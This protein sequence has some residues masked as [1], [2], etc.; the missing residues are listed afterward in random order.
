MWRW[1]FMG[2][3]MGMIGAAMKGA[4]SK[5]TGHG[6]GKHYKGKHTPV[7]A[8][9]ERRHEMLAKSRRRTA[10]ASRKINRQRQA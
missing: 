8:S 3:V 6:E 4:G 9:V 1:G 7:S 2:R 5:I 10:R